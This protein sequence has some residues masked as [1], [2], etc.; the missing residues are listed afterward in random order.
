MSRIPEE[1]S[2]EQKQTLVKA[3]T[4]H[5]EAFIVFYGEFIDLFG[6]DESGEIEEAYYQLVKSFAAACREHLMSSI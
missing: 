1:L 6:Q 4:D 2:S 5:G 3:M